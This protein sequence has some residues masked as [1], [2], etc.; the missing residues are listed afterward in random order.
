MYI[1]IDFD[2]TIVDHRFPAVGEPVPGA[3]EWMK[4]FVEA[5]GKIILFTMRSD[6][7]P[8]N[9]HLTQAVNFIESNGVELYGVNHNPTQGRW[10]TS[11]KAYGHVYID[12]AAYGCPMIHPDDFNRP[13]VDWSI[14][15]PD[16][17]RMLL[18]NT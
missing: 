12:D 8:E 18:K 7:G 16:V 3:I 5:G 10:T 14:V 15:G 11:P 9:D 2:G 13:C 6:T 1:C 4:S 17:K